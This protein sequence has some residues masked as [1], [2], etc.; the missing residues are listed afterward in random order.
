MEQYNHLGF[1]KALEEIW[2]VI[3]ATDKYLT[4]EQPWALTD[5]EADQQR[6]ATILWTTAEILR[7][8][9]AL[10]YPV[11]PEST[12]KV[13]ALLGQS[14]PLGSVNL[15]SLSFGELKPGTTLGK[16]QPLFPR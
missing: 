4:T 16:L 15:E 9:T 5:A 12:T 7:V 8:V 10:T 2:S 14:Q 3:G 1:S 13:W 11:L 6:R